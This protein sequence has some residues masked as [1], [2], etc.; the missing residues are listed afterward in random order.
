LPIEEY[1]LIGDG[2]R[3]ALV[4][5]NGSIDWLGLPRFDYRYCWL[6]EAACT[7]EALLRAGHGEEARAWRDWLLRVVA[8]DPAQLQIMYGPAGNA[9]SP[10][11]SWA[12]CPATKAPAQCGSATPH[13]SRSSWMCTGR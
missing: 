4:G 8:G 11:S 7:L 13:R 12:G 5:R 2:H 9:D 10:S 6:R 3:V 1:A